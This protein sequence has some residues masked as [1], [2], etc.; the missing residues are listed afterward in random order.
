MNAYSANRGFT[1]IE[2]LVV[3]SIIAIL[4]GLLLPA[5][6]MARRSAMTTQDLNNMRQLGMGISVYRDHVRSPNLNPASLSLL[7]E[8]GMPMEDAPTRIMVSAFDP[9]QGQDRRSGRPLGGNWG[10]YEYLLGSDVEKHPISFFYETSGEE[11]TNINDGWFSTFFPPGTDQGVVSEWMEAEFGKAPITWME[12][13]VRQLRRGNLGRSFPASDFPI[14]RNFHVYP[15]VG[16]AEE[17]S[18]RRV[19]CVSWEGNTFWSTPYWEADI[20]PAIGRP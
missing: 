10:N 12:Y 7:F 4:A 2:L 6:S 1:L 8:P 5:L 19:L 16:A 13:K 9:S 20:N 18:I 3:I 15:W 17:A 14:I 11:I